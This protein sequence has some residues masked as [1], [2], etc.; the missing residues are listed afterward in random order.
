MSESK[1]AL[2]EARLRAWMA[3]S[4]PAFSPDEPFSVERFK[5]GH[6]NL[7]Y[8]V[9]SGDAAWVLRMPPPG[10]LAAGAH[11]ISREYRVLSEVAPRFDK[12]PAVVASCDDDAALGAPFYLMEL[13]EGTIVRRDFP[14]E[15]GLDEAGKRALCHE[16]V[17]VLVELH[18]VPSELGDPEGYVERQLAGWR[19]RYDKSSTRDL[20]KA[21][22]A[23]DW[24]D[25]HLPREDAEGLVHNDY[26]LDNIVLRR[27]GDETKIRAVLDWE[28]ATRGHPLTDL[29]GALAA[30]VEREDPPPLQMM[31][32]GPTNDP[33]M[34]TREELARRYGE[35]SGR[36]TGAW[37]A[38][39]LLGLVKLG[40]VAQQLYYRYVRGESK[41]PRFAMLEF[42]IPAL[43]EWC[44][45]QI[46]A[47]ERS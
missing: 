2:D 33:G 46:A 14:E 24:L 44:E 19:E 15:L 7:T 25:R 31:K 32:L 27:E 5:G 30:W 4:V 8:G 1:G 42:A 11:D 35:L 9:R 29:G 18:A 23:F 39:Y 47:A 45:V 40:V 37:R 38:Y 16:M 3:S 41:D 22:A 36:D 21:L 10:K 34:L 43:F 28:M 12:A 13:I 6:S 20:P 17:D 26:K